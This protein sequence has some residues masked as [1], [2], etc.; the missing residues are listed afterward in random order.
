MCFPTEVSQ[1]P[2]RPSVTFAQTE[3]QLD[4][5][6][7][8]LQLLE[9]RISD[10]SV[11]LY[12]SAAQPAFTVSLELQLQALQD[13]YSKMYMLASYKAEQLEHLHYQ[14]SLKA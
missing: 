7:D 6:C 12:R 4:K 11:R 1:A 14:Q 3:A 2:V 8:Q 10:L 13:V 5:I 9:S